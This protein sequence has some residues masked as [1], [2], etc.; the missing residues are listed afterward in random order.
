MKSRPLPGISR[1]SM[2][3]LV[4]ALQVILSSGI[5]EENEKLLLWRTAVELERWLVALVLGWQLEED[6]E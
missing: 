6:V 3:S 4:P 2:Y 5:C 1:F